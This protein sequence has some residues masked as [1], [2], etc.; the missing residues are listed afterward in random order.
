MR[1]RNVIIGGIVASLVIGMW[2]M[3]VE[4]VLPDGAGFFG[5]VVAIGA[6]VV[7]D[8]QGSSNPIPFDGVA[9]ILGLAGHMMNS[10]ILAAI[11]GLVASRFLHGGST[12][13][14]AGAV[15]GIAV[16]AAMWFVV[17]PLI[18]PL[19]LNLNGLVFLIGHM[20]WGAALGLLWSRVAPHAHEHGSPVS[21]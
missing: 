8:L 4:A 7:R 9:F 3:I 1:I 15:Y 11:F 21:A 20:M 14:A 10:V 19:M 6:T 13:V 5:P 17:I 2:E 18:D 16:W 12:L